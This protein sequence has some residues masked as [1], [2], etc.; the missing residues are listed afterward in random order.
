MHA[1]VLN[2]FSLTWCFVVSQKASFSN[3]T[4][5]LVMQF[6]CIMAIQTCLQEWLRY[7]RNS[8][9]FV[10]YLTLNWL[11]CWCRDVKHHDL[12]G[13][14][15][16]PTA[17]LTPDGDWDRPDYYCSTKPISTLIYRVFV[18][19]CL[20]DMCAPDALLVLRHTPSLGTFNSQWGGGARRRFADA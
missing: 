15:P 8:Y 13:N 6:E 7:S 5:L 4:V 10:P 1:W 20:T 11:Y 17:C 19:P 12:A 2:S 18:F 16:Q 9:N 14:I 3:I